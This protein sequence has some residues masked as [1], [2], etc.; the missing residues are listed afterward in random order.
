M[1]SKLFHL[2]NHVRYTVRQNDQVWDI[3]RQNVASEEVEAKVKKNYWHDPINS[4]LVKKEIKPDGLLQ[5]SNLILR[6]K[7]VW[8]AL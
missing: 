3:W 4:S 5:V 1:H 6:A 7:R 8:K 2:F